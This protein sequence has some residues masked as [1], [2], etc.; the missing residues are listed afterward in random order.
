MVTVVVPQVPECDNGKHHCAMV[1]VDRI[2]C[3]GFI[4]N[5]HGCPE[6]YLCDR[7]GRV[8]DIPGVCITQPDAQ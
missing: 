4:R 3:G 1:G 7:R 2:A 6:G 8:P 5:Q